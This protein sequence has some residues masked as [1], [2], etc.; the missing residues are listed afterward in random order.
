MKSEIRIS[1]VEKWKFYIFYF[2]LGE[3]FQ[4]LFK[5]LN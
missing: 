5:T 2:S 4:I 1:P 3:I